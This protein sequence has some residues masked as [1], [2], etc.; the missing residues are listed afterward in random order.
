MPLQKKQEKNIINC[1]QKNKEVIYLTTKLSKALLK[2][3]KNGVT[4]YSLV[5]AKAIREFQKEHPTWIDVIDD[6]K[7][8]EHILG[9]TF[10]GAKRLPYFGAILT[11]EGRVHLFK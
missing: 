5:D 1:F 11:D 2:A 7:R 6:T 3:L 8:L 10:D 9:T 4:V